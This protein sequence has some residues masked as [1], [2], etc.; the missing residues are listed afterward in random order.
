MDVINHPLVSVILP[1]H[2]ASAYIDAAL[3]SILKQTYDNLEVILLD[4]GSTDN[5]WDIINR[6]QDERITLIRIQPNKGLIHA[7]N[8]SLSLAKGKYIARM[9]ADDISRPHRIA[10]QV[11]F[12]E[13]QPS[14]VV[15]ASSVIYFNGNKQTCK[16]NFPQKHEEI[17]ACLTLFQRWMCHPSA[18]IRRACIVEHNIT[19]RQEYEQAEDYHLWGELAKYGKLHNLEDPLL[20]YQIHEG[21]VSVKH[22]STQLQSSRKILQHHLEPF[23]TNPR[24]AYTQEVYLDYLLQSSHSRNSRFSVHELQT[25]TEELLHYSLSHPDLDNSTS[26]QILIIK[27][28]KASYLCKHS[29]GNKIRLLIIIIKILPGTFI[30]LALELHSIA[31]I[32]YLKSKIKLMNN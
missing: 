11:A 16:I 25:I 24:R 6:Y 23:L 21:Q 27:L 26:K 1:A 8:Y 12:M 22:H 29:F 28:L 19:Y 7:L 4:D 31:A 18:L 3:E 10:Q 20:H 2:N 32:G 14:Y 17:M 15:C 5:T 13:S 9:D 30:K